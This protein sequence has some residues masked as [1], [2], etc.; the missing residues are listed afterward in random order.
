MDMGDVRGVITIIT[1]ATFAGICCWTYHG[2]NRDRFEEDAML[3]FADEQKAE[4]G[5][6]GEP[7]DE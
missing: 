6:A 7:D 2:K 3:P 4:T 5:R 1:M